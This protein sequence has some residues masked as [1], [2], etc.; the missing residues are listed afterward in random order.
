MNNLTHEHTG[1]VGDAQRTIRPCGGQWVYCNGKC[2]ECPRADMRYT[3]G[4]EVHLWISY[5]RVLFVT[6]DYCQ[7][8]MRFQ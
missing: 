2:G 8:A 5:C 3:N 4:T 1:Q 6:D 7:E